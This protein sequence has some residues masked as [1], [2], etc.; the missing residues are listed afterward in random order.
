M[1]LQVIHS[2]EDIWP[3]SCLKNLCYI[4]SPRQEGKDKRNF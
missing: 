1:N 3:K 2:T 4:C